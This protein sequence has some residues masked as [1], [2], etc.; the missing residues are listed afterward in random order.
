MKRSFVLL[1]GILIALAVSSV[2]FSAPT[3]D[4]SKCP[5]TQCDQKNCPEGIKNCPHCPNGGTA[6][7]KSSEMTSKL[8]SSPM[9]SS[10]KQ[11]QSSHTLNSSTHE[12]ETSVSKVSGI[13]AS[14]KAQR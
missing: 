13:V 11:M 3:K 1:V 5:Y 6:C 9:K 7:L 12:N 2:S 8:S 4:C 10:P 14:E